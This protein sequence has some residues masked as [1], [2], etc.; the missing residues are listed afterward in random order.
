MNDT[1]P[2]DQKRLLMA[3]ALSA[4]V[5]MIWQFLFPPPKPTPPAD[6]GPSSASAP[7][8]VGPSGAAP[9]TVAA[10][11][12]ATPNTAPAPDALTDLPD[13][14][15]TLEDPGRHVLAVSSRDG[16]VRHWELIEEQYRNRTEAGTEP[17]RF[18]MPPAADHT[19]GVFLPPDVQVVVSDRVVRGVYSVALVGDAIV[20]RFEDPATRLAIE[21][22]YRVGDTPY[23]IEGKVVLA[24]LGASPIEYG[25]SARLRA[26]QNAVEASAGFMAPPVY[27][28]EG[29]CARAKDIARQNID[30]IRSNR[31]DAES[32]P[33]FTDGLRYGGV[34]NRYFLSG[35]SPGPEGLAACELFTGTEAAGVAVAQVAPDT[36]YLVARLEL[37]GGTIAPGAKVERTFE[38]YGG[39]KKLDALS[40]Q[41]PSLSEVVDFGILSPLCVTMV[42]TLRWFYSVIPNW[43]VA[44]ILLTVVVKILTLPLTHKQ[45]KSMAAMKAIQPQLKEL[46]EKYKDDRM[47]LQ[48]EMM[49]L[50]KVNGVN[51]LAGCL[52]VLAMMP[53]Y[54][55]LYKTI[56]SS[57]E[58]YHAPLGLW[59]HDL[60]ERDP[61]Y[62]LPV[63]LG[64]VFLVQARMNPPTGDAM[65]QKMMTTFMP[66][67]FTAMMLFLPSGLVVYILCNTLLG[68]AQ[69]GYMNKHYA[70]PTQPAPATARGR[71]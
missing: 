50:Y 36:S 63:L 56:Y 35:F 49:Q 45:Y 71:S 8:T 2:T 57:V 51:P 40:A 39:P 18:M 55:S 29:L 7:A 67:V 46:Q 11:A 53:V 62:I 47:R 25:L 20:A 32:M 31:S 19:R 14:V 68:I 44:I 66:I 1:Q 37:P 59:I 22:H 5:I 38:L 28:F 48:Q 69:Q 15:V 4:I 10:T 64:V 60:S 26:A 61:T 13:Q 6:G 58:L 16:Q 33:R 41:T 65:Q 27:L 54:I 43:A 3:V 70:P 17:F 34:D 42:A 12:S 52:P 24:N 30:A 21:R 9:G 23:A